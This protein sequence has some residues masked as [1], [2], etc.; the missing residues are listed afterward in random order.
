MC[1]PRAWHNQGIRYF[2]RAGPLSARV[3]AKGDKAGDTDRN[4]SRRAVNHGL[5]FSLYILGSRSYKIPKRMC[6]F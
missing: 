6:Y 3:E 1:D 4:K 5:N 2:S